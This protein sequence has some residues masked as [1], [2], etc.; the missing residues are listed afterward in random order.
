MGMFCYRGVGCQGKGRGS[1]KRVVIDLLD[2][3]SDRLKL[4]TPK[5]QESA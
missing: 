4:G 2:R 3:D 1:E 5:T